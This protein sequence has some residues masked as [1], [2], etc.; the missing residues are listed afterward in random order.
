MS[1]VLSNVSIVV[2]TDIDSH[3]STFC[4]CISFLVMLDIT[5]SIVSSLVCN[6]NASVHV[7]WTS[8]CWHN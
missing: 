4:Y 2:Y 5:D 3:I 6:L 7:C 1:I 8:V